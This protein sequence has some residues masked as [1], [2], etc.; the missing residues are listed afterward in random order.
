[1]NTSGCR[2]DG[3]SAARANAFVPADSILLDEVEFDWGETYIFDSVEKPIT[4]ISIK[5][6]GFLWRSRSSVYHYHRDDA[7]RTMGGASLDQ[8]RKKATVICIQ[9]EDSKGFIPRGGS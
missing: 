7:I 1:M 4:A 2:L 6:Y 3:L 5:S 8:G 9:V